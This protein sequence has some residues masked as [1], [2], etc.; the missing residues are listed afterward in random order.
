MNEA[1]D[2]FRGWLLTAGPHMPPDEMAF[3]EQLIS[4]TCRPEHVMLM[5]DFVASAYKRQLA[6]REAA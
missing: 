2:Y 5:V 6:K 4:E 1:C 3:A